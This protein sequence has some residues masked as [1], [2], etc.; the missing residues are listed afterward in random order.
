M[1]CDWEDNTCTN[2]CWRSGSATARLAWEE[3]R[4]CERASC[5][6]EVGDLVEVCALA[7]CPG[8]VLTCSPGM[9]LEPGCGLR[10]G[11]CPAGTACVVVEGGTSCRPS[12][13]KQLGAKCDA[14]AARYEC[15]DGLACSAERCELAC[16]DADG[17]DVC[18]PLDCDDAVA[19]THPKAPEI[20]GDGLDN[21]CDDVVDN[22][23]VV[24]EP[25]EAEPSE[26]AP[27]AAQNT[28]L[29]TSGCAGAGAGEASAAWGVAALVAMLRARRLTVRRPAR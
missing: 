26:S 20:C 28:G 21:D 25:S 14:G 24:A 7:V 27:D 18:A 19:T 15:A 1:M 22:G 5:A 2:A 9:V 8:A 23:C 10:G 6:E 17:D 12:T 3:L 29:N 16:V 11:D 13:G 4:A